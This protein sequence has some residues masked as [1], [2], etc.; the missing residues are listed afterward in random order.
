MDQLTREE[1]AKEEGIDKGIL[2]TK[3][4]FKLSTEGY[5]TSQIAKEYNISESKVKKSRRTYFYYKVLDT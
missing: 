1:T 2:L 3:K 4:V 5:I